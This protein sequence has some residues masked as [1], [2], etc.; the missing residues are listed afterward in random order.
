MEFV[1]R[2][3]G[4]YQ[5]LRLLGFGGMG[6]V[7]LANSLGVAGFEKLVDAKV[8]FLK[9]NYLVKFRKK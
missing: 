1:G 2:K 4:R 7:Y 9:E 3:L 5:L 8:D 6:E